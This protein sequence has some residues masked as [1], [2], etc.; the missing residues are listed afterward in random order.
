MGNIKDRSV[1]DI[2]D[3]K[4]KKDPKV[5]VYINLVKE[6]SLNKLIK[7]LFYYYL[8][9]KQL[10]IFKYIKRKIHLLFSRIYGFY[11]LYQI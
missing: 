2:L 9:S 7:K 10:I 6:F 5:Q 3:K 4:K 1:V 8:L 11:I